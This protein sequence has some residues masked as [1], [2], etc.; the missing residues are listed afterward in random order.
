[1]NKHK[2]TE[3]KADEFPC[4]YFYKHSWG[5]PP[6]Q[7]NENGTIEI[8]LRCEIKKGNSITLCSGD[9]ELCEVLIN[10]NEII[11]MIDDKITE[12][13]PTPEAFNDSWEWHATIGLLQELKSKIKELK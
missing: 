7:P 4:K 9:L 2:G 13:K 10:R 11:K 8:E 3:M 6:T 12:L 1:M 5:E